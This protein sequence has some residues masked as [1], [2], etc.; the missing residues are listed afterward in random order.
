[1]CA[2]IAYK[3]SKRAQFEVAVCNMSSLKIKLVDTV[4]VGRQVY[5]FVE[6]FF[7][8]KWK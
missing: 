2:W 4:L 7:N 8:A 6:I 5:S 3:G 1:M